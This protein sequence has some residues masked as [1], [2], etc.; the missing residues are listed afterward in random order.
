MACEDW[1]EEDTSTSTRVYPKPQFN[2]NPRNKERGPSLIS[3]QIP[4]NNVGKVIGKGGSVIKGFRTSYPSLSIHVSSG[5][6]LELGGSSDKEEAERCLKDIKNLIGISESSESYA[7]NQEASS[8]DW[9]NLKARSAEAQKVRW[10]KCPPLIKD[11]YREHPD[12]SSLTEDQVSK[13]RSENNGIEVS[14]FSGKDD[15]LMLNPVFRFEHAFEAYPEIMTA[16]QKRGFKNPSPIQCQAWPYLLKGLDLIGIAQTGTGK[17]LAFLLP[18]FIH[19][20]SQSIPREKRGGPNVLV[21]SPTRELALQIADEVKKYEYRGIKSVCVYG[22]GDRKAQVKVVTQGVQIVIATP[23]RLNDLIESGCIAVESITYLVLD[24]AD[25]M[26]DMGFEPQIRKI[27]LDVRP[28]RQT[29]MTSA[30]WPPGVRRLASNYMKDPITVS[31]GSLDL[32]A[33]HSVTQ[34]IFVVESEEEKDDRLLD[35][36]NNMTPEDKAIIFMSKKAK[37]DDY[38]S[39]L[40]L[41]GVDCQSIHGGRDQMDREQALLDFKLGHVRILIATDVASR[42]IDVEDISHV[43]NFDFPNSMEEYVH[44][45]GRSGRAGKKGS[46][47]S[48]MTYRD[49][50]LAQ[51]LIDIMTEANQPIP[52]EVQRLADKWAKRN[53]NR[54]Y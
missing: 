10:S 47:I 1:E 3:W 13:I 36:F 51:G 23:G 15:I 25:R 18:S 27:L 29:V 26:L 22:G 33:V 28:D 12:V 39:S 9:D 35:F 34:K 45:I 24:E 31:I 6:M 5:G 7:T 20:D 44:R 2:Q 42:G 17:T 32:A 8:I 40:C 43:I 52:R 4:P 54:N 38:S 48:F 41:A 53:E 11:F 19:I 14:S 37:V 50:P 21:L 49:R 16:I 46:S 30:T